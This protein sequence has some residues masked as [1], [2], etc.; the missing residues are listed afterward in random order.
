MLWVTANPGHQ[1]SGDQ[2]LVA[3]HSIG[4]YDRRMLGFEARAARHIWTAIWVLLLVSMVYLIR[5]TLFIFIVSLLLAYLLWPL[6]H[7]LEQRLPGRSKLPSLTIVYLSLLGILIVAGVAIGSRI[8]DQADALG[9]RIPELLAKLEQPI[10]SVGQGVGL[11]I[12][13]EIQRQLTEHSR[14]LILPVTNAILGLLSH[15]EIFLFAVL[16][17]IL[18]FFF[19]KDG[20]TL[21]SALLNAVSEES[22][23]KMINDIAD[24]LHLLLASYMRALVILGLAAAIA[25]ASFFSL[26][27]LPYALL[28]GAIAFFFEFIPLVGPLTSAA[29]VL[30][31]AG[32]S[33]FGHLAWIVVFLVVYRLFQDYILS[34]Q[35]LSSGTEVHPLLVIFG[36][37]AG[38][39]IAG[40]PGSFLSVPIMATLR[41]IYRQVQKKRLV[42]ASPPGP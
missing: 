29:V 15:A 28:L 10:G 42:V 4:C 3:T 7:F 1:T 26:I 13:T 16:V 20:K 32:L 37:L 12:L 41:I 39:Q 35:L 5:E 6:V 38:G 18:S 14:D 40:I 30:L 9:S 8:A 11:K 22:S 19:L 24:D 23:R 2:L 25:Y 27:G 36:V 31:V 21:L 33:G 17:P 34:P